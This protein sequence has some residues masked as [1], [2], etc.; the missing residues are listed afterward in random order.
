MSRRQV[1]RRALARCSSAD[2][3]VPPSAIAITT[4]NA[5]ETMAQFIGGSF[6]LCVLRS[7]RCRHHQPAA[8][9]VDDVPALLDRQVVGVR[10]HYAAA[11]G[12]HREDPVL[13]HLLL[14]EVVGK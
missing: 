14:D 12:G 11:E 9:V 10:G 8:H 4:M 1:L 5:A 7:G 6:L 2:S 13:E 3:K